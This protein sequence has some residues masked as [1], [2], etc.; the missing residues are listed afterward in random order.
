MIRFT[1]PGWTPT[2]IWGVRYWTA[3]PPVVLPQENIVTETTNTVEG[4]TVI[5]NT[6]TN[7]V[8]V[9]PPQYGYQWGY[10]YYPQYR[11][12]ATY[13]YFDRGLFNGMP[14]PFGLS[15]FRPHR[16]TSVP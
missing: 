1:R 5:N 12:P 9:R 15:S 4:Q 13:L 3:R 16:V 6:N 8:V 7:V 11:Q 2:D 14:G 10:P